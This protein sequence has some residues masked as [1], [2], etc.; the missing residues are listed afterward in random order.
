MKSSVVGFD[1]D[2]ANNFRELPPEPGSLPTAMMLNPV[3]FTIPANGSQTVRFAISRQRLNGPGEHRAMLFFSELVDTD[4]AGVKLN[5]RLGLPLYATVGEPRSLAVVNGIRFDADGNRLELDL[6]ATGN[7]Q[8]KP[9]GFYLWWPLAEYPKES[10]AL[11][12]VATLAANPT[13]TL[14]KHTAGGRLVTKPVFAGTR[15][16]V[17]AS[18]APPPDDG[19]Y[20]LI[21]HFEAGGQTVQ[22]TIEHVPAR[23]LVVD[24]K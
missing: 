24:N 21:V 19:E 6:S 14:P 16:S 23:M 20:M 18:L 4:Q 8:V 9:S 1:L 2:E 17:A 5:F 10:Q 7:T 12:E 13:R 22:R 11:K 3:E 15:R